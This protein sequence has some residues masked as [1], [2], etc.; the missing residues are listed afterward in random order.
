MSWD[1]LEAAVDAAAWPRALELAVLEWRRARCGERADL[2]DVIAARVEAAPIAAGTG[3]FHDAWLAR[4]RGATAVDLG[5][6]L[7]TLARAVPV[8]PGSSWEAGT[9]HRRHAPW[10]ARVAALAALPDDPRIAQAIVGVV[11]RAPWTGGGDPGDAAAI[12]APAIEL[13][14]RIADERSLA[15][16]HALVDRPVASRQVIREYLASALPPAIAAIERAEP[17]ALPTDDGRCARLIAALGGVRV[18]EVDLG[19]A[20]PEDEAA[21]LALVVEHPDDD[22]PR[23]VLADLWMERGDPRGELFALQLRAARGLATAADDKAIRDL[24]RQHEKTWIGDLALVTTNRVFERGLLA[25]LELRQNAAADPKQWETL[26]TDD[27]LATVRVIHKGKANETH[28]RRFVFSPAARS[29]REL[30]VVSRGMLEELCARSTPSTIEHL[31]LAFVPTPKLLA[32]I[33]SS[34]VLPR[35]G[36]L[37]AGAKP[38]QLDKLIAL[39]AAFTRERPV[40]RFGLG[41]YEGRDALATWLAAGAGPLR[42]VPELAIVEAG[43]RIV[44]GRTATGLRLEVVTDHLGSLERILASLAGQLEALSLRLPGRS[45]RFGWQDADRAAAVLRGIPAVELD[46]GWQQLIGDRLG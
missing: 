36:W 25:E 14:V 43:S 34:R 1:E 24:L 8:G 40:A 4:A 26:A 20:R 41:W 22:G 10:L 19:S 46:R 30:T 11:R 42:H 2:I 5:P 6:L 45:S 12:Y 23:E 17:V 7:A 28:Y 33:A 3:T 27:R 13:L 31:E 21:L 9:V 18:T 29:L 32:T 37:T 38:G 39:A 35:L 16:L 44:A 15:V